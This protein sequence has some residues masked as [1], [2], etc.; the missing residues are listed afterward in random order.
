MVPSRFAFQTLPGAFI[1]ILKNRSGGES[2]AN[3]DTNHELELACFQSTLCARNCITFFPLL[4]I[5]V[6]TQNKFNSSAAFGLTHEERLNKF[7]CFGFRY[8]RFSTIS[9][10]TFYSRAKLTSDENGKQNSDGTNMLFVIIDLELQLFCNQYPVK[11]RLPVG[12]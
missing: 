8:L 6:Y 9:S 12:D 2:T 3:V 11:R 4:C 10:C 7:L 5:Q 1:L